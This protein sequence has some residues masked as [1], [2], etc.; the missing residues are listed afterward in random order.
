M[1]VHT[2]NSARPE[3]AVTSGVYK[4]LRAGGHGIRGR[5]F[6]PFPGDLESTTS[7]PGIDVSFLNKSAE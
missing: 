4:A 3:G 7:E 2:A 5:P 6:R 1:D